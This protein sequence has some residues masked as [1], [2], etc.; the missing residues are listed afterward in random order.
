MPDMF[1]LTDLNRTFFGMR[2]AWEIMGILHSGY[3]LW[4]HV[5]G[6]YCPSAVAFD[7]NLRTRV[8]CFSE[9]M[10][11]YPRVDQATKLIDAPPKGIAWK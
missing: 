4:Q 2:R 9:Q 11:H 8:A 3:P 7:L 5:W 10:R 6:V 1:G